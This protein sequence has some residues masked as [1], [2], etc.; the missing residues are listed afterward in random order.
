[1]SRIVKLRNTGLVKVITI[2]ADQLRILGWDVLNGP[3]VVLDIEDNTLRVQ[4]ADTQIQR[5]K[6]ASRKRCKRCGTL[7]SMLWEATQVC[8]N[9]TRC[10][11]RCKS[12]G[13]EW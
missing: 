11:R 7:N 4:L 8:Q 12:K 2:P 9:E 10:R 6:V 5:K 3:D 13:V 1:M